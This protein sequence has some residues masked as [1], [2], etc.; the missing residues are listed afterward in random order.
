[1]PDKVLSARVYFPDDGSGNAQN[2]YDH[3]KALMDHAIA[4]A[5]Q[6]GVRVDPS[7]VRLHDCYANEDGGDTSRCTT[8]A[9]HVVGQTVEPGAE[10][11]IGVSYEVGDVVTYNGATYECISAHDSQETWEPDTAT[12]LWSEVA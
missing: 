1:M 4:A 10:W 8:I 3:V 12:S 7:W 5:R 9:K 2:A 6:V 11:E